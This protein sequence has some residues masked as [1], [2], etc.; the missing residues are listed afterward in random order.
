[1]KC[2]VKSCMLFAANNGE[3]VHLLA[4]REILFA[5]ILFIQRWHLPPL[6]KIYINILWPDN[7]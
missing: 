7:K 5:P 1:M 4:E 3:E 2:I 6:N